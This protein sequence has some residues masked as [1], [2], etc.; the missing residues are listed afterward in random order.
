MKLS[1]NDIMAIYYDKFFREQG[2][3]I[4]RH[5][6]D[7]TKRN[8]YIEFLSKCARHADA[9]GDMKICRKLCKELKSWEEEE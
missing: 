7:F 4:F 3:H 2:T 9:V 8:E 5:T 1:A 6:P